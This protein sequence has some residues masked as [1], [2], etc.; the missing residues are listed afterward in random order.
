MTQNPMKSLALIELQLLVL[1]TMD[2]KSIN[3][4][5]GSMFT[6]LISVWNYHYEDKIEYQWK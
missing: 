5:F 4:E 1:I 3:Y 6:F 2:T